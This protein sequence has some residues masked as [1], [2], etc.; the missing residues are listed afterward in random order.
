[1]LRTDRSL[2]IVTDIQ[3]T[4]ASLM[5]E[6]EQLYKKAG[7]MIEG[8][9]ILDIPILWVEQYPEGLG[10]T[11]PEI[12]SHL[13]GLTPLSKKSFSSLRDSAVEKR[14]TEF[15]RDQA[16][17]IG[18]ETHV[19]VHQT[20]MDLLDRGVETCVV[21][22]AVSSRTAF[23]KRIGLDKIARA[24]GVV[25]SVETALFELLEIA[26]GPA[27]KEILKLVK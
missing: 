8:C 9:R 23:D 21:A 5:H 25:T 7:I 14:F 1:M 16:L 2:L 22:D 18:I 15:G 27:F 26:E 10:P 4:L 17:I 20:A 24:G 13:E 3:G 11:V 19:C 6:R 12:A